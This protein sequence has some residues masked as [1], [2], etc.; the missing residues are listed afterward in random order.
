MTNRTMRQTT[1]DTFDTYLA[2]TSKTLTN[3]SIALGSNNGNWNNW[4]RIFNSHV[5]RWI[6][7]DTNRIRNFTNKTLTTPV[8]ASF[9]QTSGSNLITALSQ[10]HL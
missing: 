1:V 9:N 3:K 4:Y 8:I 6:I 10:I 2:A 5:I 7:C